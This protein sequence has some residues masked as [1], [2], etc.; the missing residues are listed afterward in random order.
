MSALFKKYLI[1]FFFILTLTGLSACPKR[2][3]DEAEAPIAP[4]SETHLQATPLADGAIFNLTAG[5]VQ[6]T[7]DGVNYDML[8]YNGT[9][10]GPLFKVPPND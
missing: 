3:L 5:P 7:I 6:K 2:R 10:P 8:G 9:I 4:E 1:L